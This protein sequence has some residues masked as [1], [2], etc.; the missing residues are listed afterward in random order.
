MRDKTKYWK[1]YDGGR[2]Q[3]NRLL[4]TE[5][6]VEVYSLKG[7]W[8]KRNVERS[9]KIENDLDMDYDEI[10]EEEAMEILKA[11]GFTPYP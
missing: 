1:R 2:E 8:N 5:C 9:V 4:P 3:I 6:V 7:N 10:T 11:Q